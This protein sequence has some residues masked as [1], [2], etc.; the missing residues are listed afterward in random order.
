MVFSMH[1]VVRMS[2]FNRK[3]DDDRKRDNMI[4]RRML[5]VL[6]LIVLL[7]IFTLPADTIDAA[8]LQALEDFS[9]L[10]G[11]PTNNSIT[12]NIIP[13]E[14]GDVSFEYGTTSGVY[15]QQSGITPCI[16]D[17]PVEVVI[18]GLT[19]NTRYYYRLLFRETESSP[20]TTGAE[21]SFRTQ[22]AEGD[23][24]TFTI[25]SDSHLGQYGG[26]TADQKAL[27]EQTLLNVLDDNPDFH[28][29]LGDTFPMDPSPL[30]T[31]MTD[32]EAE[33]AYLYQRPYMD[34]ISQSIPIFL[35]VGNHEN[36]EGWNFDD[37]FTAPDQSLAKV[38]LKYRKIYYPNPVPDDFYS[39]NSDPLPEAIGGDTFHEDYYAWT[40]GDALF[41][42]L[43]PYHYSMTW[44]NDDGQGYGGE[45]QDGEPSGDRWDWTYGEIQYNWFKQTLEES[46]AK[47]KFVFSHQV[48]GGVIPY[49]R[50]GV[51]A[52]PYFEWGGLNWDGTPG[53]AAERPGWEA[54][55][56]QI[57]V[58]NGVTIFFHGHDHFYSREML[59][60]IVYLECPK[61]D[62]DSYSMGYSGDGGSYP[63]GINLTSS[64]HIRV[65]VS[66]DDVSVDYVRAYLPGDG[67]NGVIADSFTV[68]T[69]DLTLAVNPGEAGTTTPAAGIH[70]FNDGSIVEVTAAP[71]AG[72]IFSHWSGACS[73]SGSCSVAMNTDKSVTANF[74]PAPTILGDVNGDEEFNSTDALIILSG[75]VGINIWQF[76]PLNCGD[77]NGDGLVNSTD[78]LIIISYDVGFTVPFPVG[79]SGCPSSVT[80]CPGCNP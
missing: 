38:G 78:A 57:M 17:E 44:P 16:A 79:E 11:R 58:D 75:D 59:D 8:S 73:G 27:Y 25:I 34:L 30:G 3:L 35:A 69:Y 60:E 70:T 36:E 9:I 28:I 26:G 10:L 64:G 23:S 65:S 52:A 47:Y 41:V 53:F 61:P 22:R 12:A 6:L 66:P 40:W 63:T 19:S 50:G 46:D 2:K 42:V 56:H 31:G 33:T 14:S 29:D 80:P 55:I 76:C 37:V 43:D 18:S 49:G 1:I 5:T 21:Y 4:T 77:V 74:N 45:G 15:T 32:Q 48:T 13:N 7:S 51:G 67:T 20:W 24:F 39:G 54:P 71:A 72:Y 62:D 68:A